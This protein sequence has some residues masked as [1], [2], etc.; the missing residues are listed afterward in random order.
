MSPGPGPLA[1]HF[2]RRI[3]PEPPNYAE[4]RYELDKPVDRACDAEIVAL[5]HACRSARERLIVLLI[6]R[7]GLR[8]SE[9]TRLQRSDLHLLA[10]NRSLGCPVDSAALAGRADGCRADDARTSEGAGQPSPASL[11]ARCG[12]G[13]ALIRRQSRPPCLH[14]SMLKPKYRPV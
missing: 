3:P 8:H 10:D 12:A 7:A 1:C 11:G 4:R 6:S 5:L 13:P 14:R 9:V 2:T